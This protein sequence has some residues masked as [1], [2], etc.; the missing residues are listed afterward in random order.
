[1]SDDVR[2]ALPPQMT[3]SHMRLQPRMPVRP[4]HHQRVPMPK[5]AVDQMLL[6]QRGGPP[7]TLRASTDTPATTH[8]VVGGAQPLQESTAGAQGSTQVS[9]WVPRKPTAM[10]GASMR[11]DGKW[12]FG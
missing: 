1:M 3:Y 4:A 12:A 9:R 5:H 7:P 11:M 6:M 2:D 10:L 8:Q